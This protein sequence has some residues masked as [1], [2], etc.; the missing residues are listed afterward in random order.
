MSGLLFGE[1][2]IA[3]FESREESGVF[4]SQSGDFVLQ[5]GVFLAPGLGFSL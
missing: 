2:G 3:L 5:N 1:I 4:V